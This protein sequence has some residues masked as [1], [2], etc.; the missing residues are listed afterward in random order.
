[1]F[2]EG[3]FVRVLGRGVGL[4]TFLEEVSTLIASFNWMIRKALSKKRYSSCFTSE[5]SGGDLSTQNSTHEKT[6]TSA[7]HPFFF[8]DQLLRVKLIG[9]FL[10]S[11]IVVAP[12]MNFAV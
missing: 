7:P 10:K 5:L 12:P 6:R 4:K 2:K 11:P 9:L 1:M 3:M 8:Q